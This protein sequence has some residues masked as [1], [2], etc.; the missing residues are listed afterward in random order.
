MKESDIEKRERIFSQRKK[1]GKV[2]KCLSMQE[3]PEYYMSEDD[4]IWLDKW[5]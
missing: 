5:D 4:F 2:V 3:G 1:L